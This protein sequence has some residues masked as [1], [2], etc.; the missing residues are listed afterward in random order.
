MTA[1]TYKFRKAVFSKEEMSG[2]AVMSALCGAKSGEMFFARQGAG[3]CDFLMENAS[4]K[5]KKALAAQAKKSICGDSD[6]TAPI[7]EL[8]LWND[9]FAGSSFIRAFGDSFGDEFVYKFLFAPNVCFFAEMLKNVFFK[10]WSKYA[11]ATVSSELLEESQKKACG[12]DL[13]PIPVT[14]EESGLKELVDMVVEDGE[15]ITLLA[16]AVHRLKCL[17]ALDYA[18]YMPIVHTAINL[19]TEL[20][21][22]ILS[23]RGEK[24][25]EEEEEEKEKNPSKKNSEKEKNSDEEKSSDDVKDDAKDDVMS[26]NSSDSESEDDSDDSDDSDYSDS[27]SEEDD[28]ELSKYPLIPL[29]EPLTAIAGAASL[30]RSLRTQALKALVWVA[31]TPRDLAGTAGLFASILSLS[32][33]FFNEAWKAVNARLALSPE[34]G[35]VVL[36]LI[37]RTLSGVTKDSTNGLVP[38]P[39]FQETWRI[40]SLLSEGTFADLV[41]HTIQLLRR[42]IRAENAAH[43][44]EIK[45]S[46]CEAIGDNVGPAVEKNGE[47]KGMNDSVFAI[48]FALEGL[49][50]YEPEGLCSAALAGLGKVA[51][52]YP[53]AGPHIRNFVLTLTRSEDLAVVDEVTYLLRLLAMIDVEEEEVKQELLSLL[54]S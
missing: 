39:L 9:M 29:L 40:M 53:H 51:V 14:R 24:V 34:L 25:N 47:M 19:A 38:L 26:K 36:A 37:S 23:H 45:R 44:H 43:Y 32:P 1:R 21:K 10:N 15:E 54:W 41:D 50:S 27:D 28:E 12:D 6:K 33:F 8:P 48:I 22:E 42:P 16:A 31:P 18:K 52:A 49:C 5:G 11:D 7:Y 30:P 35:R 46:L 2:A 20:G 3:F 17:L 13:G 4:K